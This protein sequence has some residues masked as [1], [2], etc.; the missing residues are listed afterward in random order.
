MT[1]QRLWTLGIQRKRDKLGHRTGSSHIGS[2][3][4]RVEK[5]VVTWKAS[6]SFAPAFGSLDSF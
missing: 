2:A 5:F 6:V 3:K 4:D 1:Q